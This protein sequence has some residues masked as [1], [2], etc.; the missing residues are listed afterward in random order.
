M[1]NCRCVPEGLIWVIRGHDGTKL[2]AARTAYCSI[3]LN[4]SCGQGGRESCGRAW[5]LSPV[6]FWEKQMEQHMAGRRSSWAANCSKTVK[7]KA[8][9][10]ELVYRSDFTEPSTL[11]WFDLLLNHTLYFAHVCLCRS[12]NWIHPI[13]RKGPT[14]YTNLTLAKSC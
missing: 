10:R 7:R 6:T 3:H 9:M 11:H 13:L 1:G 8:N 2:A 12:T 5:K 14:Y 4:N